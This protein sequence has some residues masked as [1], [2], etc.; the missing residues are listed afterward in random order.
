MEFNEL[1]KG[2]KKVDLGIIKKSDV[3]IFRNEKDAVEY[4]NDAVDNIITGNTDIAAI[5]LKKVLSL[6]PDFDEAA[7][8]L[9][10][11]KEYEKF[12]SIGDR[13]QENIRGKAKFGIGNK[14]VK[15][16]LPQRLHVSPRNLLKT[17]IIII[18]I[19]ATAALCVVLIK[20]LNNPEETPEKNNE[21]SYSQQEVYLLNERIDELE[22]NLEKSE[23]ET[24]EALSDS[25]SDKARIAELESENE[26]L[27]GLLELYRAAVYFNQGDYVLSADLVKSL[28][29]NIYKGEDREIYNDVYIKAITAAADGLY[30]MGLNLFSQKDYPG[31]IEHLEKVDDYS[32]DFE[33]L[34]NCYYILGKAYYEIDNATRSIELYEY[35][36]LNIEFENITGLLYYTGKAYQKLGN[37][38]KAREL[39]NT[40]ITD[41]PYSSLVG[42]SKD[43]LKEMETQ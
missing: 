2:L 25:N 34:G 40:L 31:T 26:S 32:P 8:L 27:A 6:S 37:F 13:V 33:E 4:Y 7:S 16:N 38:E 36:S 9:E 22:K 10:R 21:I 35:I 20:L 41:H 23:T 15:R 18:V 17:I 1:L 39:Y 3:K 42:Y 29:E 14:L 24:Q 30:K 11:L 19:A 5:K 28:D 12:R 43:R